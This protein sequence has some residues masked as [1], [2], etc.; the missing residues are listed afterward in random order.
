MPPPRAGHSSQGTAHSRDPGISSQGLSS[1]LL[2]QV[3]QT[4]TAQALKM[5]L[6][7]KEA[8]RFQESCRLWLNECLWL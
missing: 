2:P 7:Q 1:R 5:F 3:W 4:D 8:R 6:S